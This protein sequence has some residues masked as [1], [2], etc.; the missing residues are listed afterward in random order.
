MARSVPSL[1]ALA[2]LSALGFASTLVV[3]RFGLIVHE[4]VGHGGP[5][6]AMG[7]T[8]SELK[9]FWFA[10]GR[11]GYTRAAPWTLPEAITIQLGGIAL[12]LLLALGLVL[13]ARRRAALPRILL[14]GA[15]AGF[16][17][18]AAIYLATGVFYGKGDG[19]IVHRVLGDWRPLVWA[20]A[21][22]GCVAIAYAGAR[23]AI[24]GLRAYAP[25]RT[26]RGQLATV[27]VALGIAGTAMIALVQTELA[28]RADAQYT[29]IMKSEGQR[30][31]DREVAAASAAGAD[32]AQLEAA[33]R[34]AESRHAPFPFA[35]LLF[36]AMGLGAAVGGL[37]SPAAVAPAAL[38]WRSV[39]PVAGLAALG[40]AAVIVIDLLT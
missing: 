35:P 29:A 11:I 5:A 10:G 23:A 16:A 2:P 30:A 17:G 32:A 12:E 1:S 18:H 31:V 36:A 20:P 27:A 7:A 22:A 19:T 37:R 9:L 26:A 13:I 34:A 6:T 39:A 14:H 15:A 40:V 28:V 25:A 21:A 24:G 38:A 33:R 3:T 8:I 4:L